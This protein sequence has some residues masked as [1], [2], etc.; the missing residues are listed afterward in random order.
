LRALAA[1]RRTMAIAAMF[2]TRGQFVPSSLLTF[3]SY[4]AQR[5]KIFQIGIVECAVV[6]LK[7]ATFVWKWE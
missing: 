6:K 1:L 5:S 7:R 4:F 2:Q 3:K